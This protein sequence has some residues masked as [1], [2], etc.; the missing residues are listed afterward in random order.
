VNWPGALILWERLQKNWSQEGLCR[1]ICA[2]SYLSK[3]E[4][5]KAEPSAEITRLLLEKLGLRTDD[6]LEKLAAGVRDRAYEALFSGDETELRA[7]MDELDPEACRATAAGLDLLLLA[8]FAGRENGPLDGALEPAMDSR[9]L[10]LQRILQGRASDALRLF[11][12][13][14]TYTQAGTADYVR[15][16]YT[17]ALDALETGYDLAA[18]EGAARL[19]LRCKLLTGNCYSNLMDPENMLR[20]YAPARR[21]AEA[22]GD[23]A[24]L[25]GIDY[26]IAASRIET[27][28]CEGAYR[29]FSA[30]E[31]PNLMSLHKLAI[32]CEKTGRT[33]EARTAL[34]RADALESD[35]PPTTLCREMCALVRHRLDRP[36]Y[37]EDPRYGERLMACFDT[38]R[39][40]LPSGYAV[41][42]LPWVLEWLEASRQY[43][44]AYQFL[45]DFPAYRKLK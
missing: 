21:L 30:L 41:F 16:N 28:D 6:K 27:G 7:S 19:M 15:G 14:F 37:L 22:L 36:D 25:R 5:G 42:H 2:V 4:Q 32:C 44:R 3:I 17:A 38:C 12:S 29:Y 31:E 45:L 20:H 10:S 35:D 26:N 8:R 40:K 11:P 33:E 1:G 34:D 43:K 13:A 23:R 39:R 24:V 9:Q 18:R